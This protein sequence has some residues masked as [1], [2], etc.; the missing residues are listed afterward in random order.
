MPFSFENHL[1]QFGN[2]ANAAGILSVDLGGGAFLANVSLAVVI[3]Q[4]S[5]P[6]IGTG[7]DPHPVWAQL[8]PLFNGKVQTP[9]LRNVDV[10]PYPGFVKAYGHNGYF[11][12]LKAIVHFYNTRD[13]LNG[14]VHLPAGMPGEGLTY[15]PFPEVNANLDQTIGNL[16]LTATT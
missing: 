14:G 7:T 1:D 16:W 2:I 5:G 4:Q 13:T 3:G 8:A 9:T 6:G 12:S 15:W 11:K 10:R